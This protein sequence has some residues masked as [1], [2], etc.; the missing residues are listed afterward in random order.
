MSTAAAI[1]APAIGADPRTDTEL[2]IA[3]RAAM[4]WVN[5]RSDYDSERDCL[6][7]IGD[8]ADQQR[9]E[10]PDYAESL[11]AIHEAEAWLSDEQFNRFALALIQVC[12][13][14]PGLKGPKGW[15]AIHSATARQ[16]ALAFLATVQPQPR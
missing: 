8:R 15:R 16:R 4:G 12:A 2:S 3:I 9:V 14:G 5:V 6:I 7:L 1:S 11:D 13:G 10:V